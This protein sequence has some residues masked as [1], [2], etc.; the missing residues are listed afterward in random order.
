MDRDGVVLAEVT[1]DH[2]WDLAKRF[3]KD[4]GIDS[5]AGVWLDEE[6]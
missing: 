4:N 2:F 6:V 5:F 3:I 1:G